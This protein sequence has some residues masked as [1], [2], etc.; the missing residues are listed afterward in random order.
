MRNG[1]ETLLQVVQ[2]DYGYDLSFSL[3]DSSGQALDLSGATLSFK[4]QTESDYTV[5]FDNPMAIVN[6]SS[7]LCKY[8]VLATDF[9][10]PGAWSAQIV[11]TYPAGEVLTFTG[12]TVNVDP[13]LPLS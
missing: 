6:A 9:V 8:S 2:N 13:E 12:I 1:F 3:Q 4:A 7:G 5:E 10:V 11:V